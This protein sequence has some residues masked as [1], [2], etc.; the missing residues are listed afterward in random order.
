MTRAE[1][2]RLRG[3]VPGTDDEGP[4]PAEDPILYLQ[5]EKDG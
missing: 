2:K 1:A 4:D 3:E 5:E